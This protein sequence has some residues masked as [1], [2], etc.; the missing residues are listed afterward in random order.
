MQLIELIILILIN[1]NFL[2]RKLINLMLH[3][4]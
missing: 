4:Y 3:K 1:Q 2:N